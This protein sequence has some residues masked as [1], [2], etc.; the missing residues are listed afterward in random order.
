MSRDAVLAELGE[1]AAALPDD[2]SDL[3]PEPLPEPLNGRRRTAA[4]K[5]EHE[6]VTAANKAK[7]VERA[8]RVKVRKAERK[9]D[10][11]AGWEGMAAGLDGEC[12][13]KATAL[14][15]A[16]GRAG[17]FQLWPGFDPTAGRKLLKHLGA[18]LFIGAG[19]LP[20]LVE[21]RT[22]VKPVAGRVPGLTT[23][24]VALTGGGA[25]D[26][27]P[28][29]VP[30]TAAALAARASRLLL[31]YFYDKKGPT[32]LD[33]PRNV[34]AF[35]L[36]Q[37]CV[38]EGATGAAAIPW[39]LATT[40]LPLYTEDDRLLTTGGL[41]PEFATYVSLDFL[42][43]VPDRPTYEQAQAAH[44]VLMHPFRGYFR[45]MLDEHKAAAAAGILAYALTALIRPTLPLA[46][47]F[48]VDGNEIGAGK[49]KVVQ[50][51][52]CMVEGRETPATSEGNSK[53]ELD[54]R[55]DS[56]TMKGRALL[57]I[58]NPYRVVDSST[59]AA[60]ATAADV[61]IRQFQT[62]S[63][64]DVRALMT[65]VIAGNNVEFSLDFYRR[66]VPI[67]LVI[68]GADIAGRAFDFD[69][70]DEALASRAALV[71]AG[72]TVLRYWAQSRDQHPSVGTA[73]LGSY[74]A[75]SRRVAG[76]VELL[77]GVSPVRLVLGQ[78]P[79]NQNYQ[80][81]AAIFRILF[82]VF[83]A[84]GFTAI[85]AYAKAGQGE[86]PGA[87]VPPRQS[88]D[89]WRDAIPDGFITPKRVGRWL[90][91]HRDQERGG[92]RLECTA[93]KATHANTYRLV[94]VGREPVDAFTVAEAENRA[95]VTARLAK[96]SGN[97]TDARHARQMEAMAEVAR[98]RLRVV[99]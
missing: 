65:I 30:A 95:R 79:R 46:P 78:R 54:K 97:P 39:C 42:P 18:H 56:A 59:L 50:T 76:A 68:Q 13:Q 57:F 32:C 26:G 88:T 31:F 63:A 8:R 34:A 28:Q 66:V 81:E 89:V 84:A 27:V 73:T 91:R 86:T 58:D 60:L 47:I 98:A 5:A 93:D 40:G 11:A 14:A 17:A 94:R 4:E 9:N 92:L 61:S 23:G 87:G 70:C 67:R 38:G 25:V 7:R 33:C 74:A 96:R 22:P 19:L 62:L 83:G 69:P 80:E 35:A 49:G 15:L 48:A 99:D 10:A 37:A 16:R 75:W 12:H 2:D 71:T 64:V 6:R 44:A 90:T 3:E 24:R 85:Q 36:A 55:I 51:V 77:T 72:L 82:E 43:E 41:H 1:L 45:D 21:C 53:E 29:L 20:V 52:S